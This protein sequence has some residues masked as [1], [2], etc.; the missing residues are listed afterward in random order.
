MNIEATEFLCTEEIVNS[1]KEKKEKMSR[2]FR[3]RESLGS[4]IGISVSSNTFR[5]F[6][7]MPKQPS[8]VYRNW[9]YKKMSDKDQIND[10]LALRTQHDYDIWLK[11]FSVELGHHWENEMGKNYA[12]TYGQQRKLPNLLMKRFCLYD[13]IKNEERLALIKLLHV[14]LEKFTLLAI[15]KCIHEFPEAKIVGRIPT[16]PSMSFIVSEQ[17]YDAIQSVF[18]IITEQAGVPLIYLDILAWDESH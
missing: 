4:V 12:L 8:V 10:I 1:L 18:R 15:R 11:N 14:P 13:E 17:M 3:K 16:N 6:Q 2:F 9:A 7:H 5:A